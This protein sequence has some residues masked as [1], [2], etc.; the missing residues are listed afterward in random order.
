MTFKD[1]YCALLGI[2]RSHKIQEPPLGRGLAALAVVE[3][4]KRNTLH[5]HVMFWST[6]KPELLQLIAGSVYFERVVCNIIDS[7]YRTELPPEVHLRHALLYEICQLR[8]P[9]MARETP[10]NLQNP[11]E[12]TRF[13]DKVGMTVG[14]HTHLRDTCVHESQRL[15]VVQ[16]C[17]MGKGTRL[18]D[19]TEVVQLSVDDNDALLIQ[20]PSLRSPSSL[21][22]NIE[23]GVG[24]TPCDSRPLMY[25]SRRRAMYMSAS[26]QMIEGYSLQM[27]LRTDLIS[28]ESMNLWHEHIIQYLNA[29]LVLDAEEIESIRSVSFAMALKLPIVLSARNA[30][31]VD[32]NETAS[33]ALRCNTAMYMLGGS[34]QCIAVFMYLVKYISKDANT[35]GES[36]PLIAKAMEYIARYPTAPRESETSEVRHLKKFMQR[37]LNSSEGGTREV[38]D[39]L[40]AYANIGGKGHISTT[41]FTYSFSWDASRVCSGLFNDLPEGNV[42]ESEEIQYGN[43]PMY[44]LENNSKIAMSQMQVYLDRVNPEYEQCINHL[45]SGEYP[46]DVEDAELQQYLTTSS[47]LTHLSLREFSAL[48]NIESMDLEADSNKPNSR[49]RLLREMRNPEW[50]LNQGTKPGRLPCKRFLLHHRNALYHT[51]CL[52]LKAK[53][54]AVINA[55]GKSPAYPTDIDVPG[56]LLLDPPTDTY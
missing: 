25:V 8:K 46:L 50:K 32:F 15:H 1:R 10:Y 13:A 3:E 38:S 26:D 37:I 24:L 48:L 7:I 41:S 52:N 29:Y 56:N 11:E 53:H 19:R 16:K 51:H 21:R 42:E 43:V 9:R 31:V 5:A 2:E 4:N 27:D 40:A 44:T 18:Q 34:E 36:L 6:L 22:A 33:A 47:L 49:V 23:H 28:T 12:L 55:G 35:L 30:M 14:I 17:R 20:P 54:S 39:T 45:L